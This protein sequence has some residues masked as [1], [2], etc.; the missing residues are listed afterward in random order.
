[1]LLAVALALTSVLHSGP[2][3]P[4]V[5]QHHYVTGGWRITVGHDVFT[6]AIVCTLKTSRMRYRN[7]TLIF[8][9]KRGLET[10]HAFYKLDDGPAHPVSDAFHAVEAH[11]FFP[12]RGWV[13]DPAGGDVAL[14]AADVRDAA[15]IWIRASPTT[16]PS[17]F[18]INR[19]GDAL[20]R[21]RSEGC[22]EGSFKAA[23]AA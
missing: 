2:H 16:R 1:M 20:D 23:A 4:Q 14:P 3:P 8:H 21:A 18:K 6:D 10:T 12:R 17:Y 9:L 22:T 13:D 11:G 5:K 19:F 7:E 15:R